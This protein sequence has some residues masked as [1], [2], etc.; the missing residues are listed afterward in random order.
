[1][2]DRRSYS[3]GGPGWKTLV[4]GLAGLVAVAGGLLVFGFMPGWVAEARH[5]TVQGPPC[6]QIAKAAFDAQAIE[7]PQSMVFDD[8]G[9]T[10]AYGHV[11][12]SDIHDRGGRGFGMVGVCQFSGPGA[13]AVRTPQGDA[14]YLVTGGKPVA[15][16]IGHGRPTCVVGTTEWDKMGT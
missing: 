5:W 15:V 4:L 10:R 14:Y 7:N 3:S 9:F 6:P 1:M 2:I 16:T 8:A 11:S 13:L 12:C